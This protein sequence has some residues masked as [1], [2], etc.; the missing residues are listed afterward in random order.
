MGLSS[1]RFRIGPEN[2]RVLLHTGR[3]GIGSRAGHDLTLEV[4]DWSA[5]VEVPESGPAEAIVTARL[6][7]ATLTVRGGT[8]GARPLTE[9]DRREIEENA[10]RT[11]GVE[12]QTAATFE[13]SRVVTDGDG[14]TIIG[15]LTLR[16]TATPIEVR[17]RSLAPGHYRGTA[18][19]KQS[20]YGV[21]PYSAFL[22]ALK[23]RDDVEV[24][25]EVDVA[26]AT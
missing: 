14:G 20:A 12:D 11:L 24:E 17:V 6:E 8:G 23:V 13:S 22:G 3:E 18:V 4:T 7:L 19:M 2:G 1:G 10:R 16:G 15:T 21:K 25:I 5:Q 9:K 26:R